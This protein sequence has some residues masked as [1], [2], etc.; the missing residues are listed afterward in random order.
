MSYLQTSIFKQSVIILCNFLHDVH[1]TKKKESVQNQSSSSNFLVGNVSLSLSAGLAFKIR[2]R[3]ALYSFACMD[4]RINVCDIIMYFGFICSRRAG[5][6]L[7]YLLFFWYLFFCHPSS[8]AANRRIKMRGSDT[9]TSIVVVLTPP[10]TPGVA[11][12]TIAWLWICIFFF[13][14]SV[15]KR[16]CPR[17][18]KS[19]RPQKKSLSLSLS[20]VLPPTSRADHFK[21][22][23]V[24]RV[25]PCLHGAE[26]SRRNSS[27]ES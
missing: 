2:A 10:V 17:K 7:L 12:E 6:H 18:R 1:R 22:A 27:C 8:L 15:S 23:V 14:L 4:I 9:Q 5:N 13:F 26:G 11:G 21:N 3:C 16:K 24:L 19:E 20:T 25:S